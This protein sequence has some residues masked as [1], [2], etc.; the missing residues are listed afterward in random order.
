VVGL[1]R[2]LAREVGLVE[3][4]VM[5]AAVSAS[6]HC[7]FAAA[8]VAAAKGVVELVAVGAPGYFVVEAQ[9]LAD[10]VVDLQMHSSRWGMVAG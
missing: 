5:M 10:S 9:E 3:E 7:S 2:S 4:A 8:A 1:H 6:F